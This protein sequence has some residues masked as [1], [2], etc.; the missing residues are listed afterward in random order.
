MSGMQGSLALLHAQQHGLSH[1]V[2]AG[3]F[4]RGND[5]SSKAIMFL[6]C[7]VLNV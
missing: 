6:D 5:V 4:L 1:V 2:F 3:N 7:M